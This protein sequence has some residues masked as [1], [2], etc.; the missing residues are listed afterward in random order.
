MIFNMEIKMTTVAAVAYNGG[1]LIAADQQGT[2]MPTSERLHEAVHKLAKI[3]PNAVVGFAGVP[4]VAAVVEQARIQNDVWKRLHDRSV[5][6]D[7]H[8]RFLKHALFAW[9]NPGIGKI[10]D[11][12]FVAFD[13][14][15]ERARI[16]SI[17]VVYTGEYRDSGF[18]SIGSG[19]TQV[20]AALRG[21][22]NPYH[23]DGASAMIRLKAV[24][25]ES[26]EA[27][28][29]VGTV[30]DAFRISAEGVEDVSAEFNASAGKGG[31]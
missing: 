12:L 18:H 3:G 30:F 20:I 17:G 7:G 9:M 29:G 16:F 24:M 31:E 10:G 26:A 27:N 8:L 14:E 21:K 2:F 28:A 13:C 19:S 4:E 15:L 22:Y 11:L 6:P 1:A 25:R 23:A 5:S